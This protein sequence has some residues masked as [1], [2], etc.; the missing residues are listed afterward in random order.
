ME[1]LLRALSD[2]KALYYMT[3]RVIMTDVIV[4]FKCK[5]TEKIWGG[6]VSLKYPYDIQQV[7]RRKLR[8][9][10]NAKQLK[11]LMIPPNN[12]LE[13]LKGQRKGEYSIRIN[14]QWRLCFV[15]DNNHI[16]DVKIEDY[17]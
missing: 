9:L 14:R 12:C 16:H 13:A 3:W 5:E 6:L 2:C 15:W 17:H 1:L 10:N 11:D 4:N 7:A 8:M